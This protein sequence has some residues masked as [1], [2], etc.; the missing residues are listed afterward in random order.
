MTETQ[1]GGPADDA[2]QVAPVEVWRTV[3]E[4]ARWLPISY[5]FL[6]ALI[7]ST[8]PILTDGGAAAWLVVGALSVLP[9]LRVAQA[10]T[11]M[12]SYHA[13]PRRYVLL[14]SGLSLSTVVAYGML[15]ALALDL[16]GAD[17]STLLAVVSLAGIA[18]GGASS[19]SLVRWL[20]VTF[21]IVA[22]MPLVIASLAMYPVVALR[23]PAAMCVA[24]AF[25]TRLALE[26]HAQSTRAFALQNAYAQQAAHLA[27]AN[28][29]AEVAS[30]AKSRFLASMS[31]ELRTPMNGVIGIAELLAR[32]PLST[33]QRQYVEVIQRSGRDLL[34]LLDTILDFSR[35]EA[36]RVELE[37]APFDPSD[38]IRRVVEL[39]RP[40]AECKS[41]ELCISLSSDIPGIMYGDA[42]RVRQVVTNLVGNAIK[43]TDVGR[44]DVSASVAADA[45]NAG[46]ACVRIE[47]ADTG[48]GMD[49]GAC[50]RIFDPF[51]Q[52]DAS[53]QRR[54]SGTGLGLSISRELVQ[55]MGGTLSVASRLGAGSTFTLVLPLG[56]PASPPP[57]ATPHGAPGRDGPD[58]SAANARPSRGADAIAGAADRLAGRV[59]VVEDNAVN[60]IVVCGMLEQL[61]C[62]AVA[63]VSGHDAIAL[64]E[65]RTFDLVLM[66]R[67]LPGIDGLETV[68][69]IRASGAAWARIPIVA[70][71][72]HALAEHREQCLA[73]GMDDYLSKPLWIDGLRA[74]L[75]P[76]L[77]AKADAR[78]EVP[79]ALGHSSA[80]ARDDGRDEAATRGLADAVPSE[81]PA[82]PALDPN[83]IA[84]LLDIASRAG[85]DLMRRLLDAYS[86]FTD[87]IRP[88]LATAVSTCDRPMVASLCHALVSASANLGA[89]PLADACRSLERDAP[90]AA[91]SDVSHRVDAIFAELDRVRVELASCD[92]PREEDA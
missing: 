24:M 68:R 92:K 20:A 79:V 56:S 81:A 2:G 41:L 14:F 86:E 18:A 45:A 90:T 34:A 28:R 66:D 75:A 30:R 10:R 89:A 42:M 80:E 65:K 36:G 74:R 37:R 62:E 82:V 23:V 67:E 73:A 70:L 43:F 22:C 15:A 17:A 1:S 35:V 69:R 32:S 46:G 19:L 39:L 3:S 21:V 52:V 88:E 76:W 40:T 49:A 48:V 38:V 59:L 16:Y 55:C 47:V 57:A 51:T 9:V 6:V 83:R 26:L 31:H 33:Q 85:D 61:G 54:L 12:S 25:Y 64:L 72:A 87:R 84:F 11:F 13:S 29:D 5:L 53:R 58:E 8:T 44:V 63:V 77:A 78:A 7:V 50:A 60:Q 27:A 4:R 91:W 71:T